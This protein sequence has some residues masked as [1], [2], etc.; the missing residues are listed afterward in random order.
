MPLR[1]GHITE[2]WKFLKETLPKFNWIDEK[3]K[4]QSEEEQILITD[5]NEIK[6]DVSTEKDAKTDKSLKVGAKPKSS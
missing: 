6:E 2:V 5:S 4:A 3:Q 1:F